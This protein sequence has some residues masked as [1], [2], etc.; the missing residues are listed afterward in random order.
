MRTL[1]TSPEAYQKSM[2]LRIIEDELR[3]PHG[4]DVGLQFLGRLVAVAR[5]ETDETVARQLGRVLGL[6]SGIP[7]PLDAPSLDGRQQQLREWVDL[8]RMTGLQVEVA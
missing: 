7:C 3:K 1:E 4:K 2:Q 8:V 6:L 5:N